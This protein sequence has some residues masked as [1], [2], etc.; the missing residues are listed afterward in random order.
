MWRRILAYILFGL[1]FLTLTF[2]KHYT[3]ELIPYPF[4]FWL[5]GLALFAGGLLFLRYTPDGRDLEARKKLVAT[6]ADLKNNGEKIQVDLSKCEIKEHSYSEEK[7]R[8]GNDNP[9]LTLSI[10]SEIQGWN[11][12]GGGGWRNVVA[13]QI[14]ADIT[15]IS[16]F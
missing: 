1:G 9:L 8:Y 7:Q 12:L 15:L 2:F 13:G 5:V 14:R 3:G 16:T 10:E 11:T 6:I 4:L